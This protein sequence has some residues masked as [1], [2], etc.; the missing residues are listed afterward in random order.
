M[1]YTNVTNFRSNLFTLLENTVKY[2]ET[3]QVSTK[4]GNAVVMSE[5]D[6]NGLIETLHLCSLPKMRKKIMD[7]L[8]TEPSDCIDENE[9]EF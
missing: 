5:E 2:N 7:G 1:I 9:L 8:N 3:V 6:Y 4:E